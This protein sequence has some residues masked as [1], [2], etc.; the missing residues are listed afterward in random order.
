VIGSEA[1]GDGISLPNS[2][3]QAAVFDSF[4]STGTWV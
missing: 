2:F 4:T 3:I 1:S